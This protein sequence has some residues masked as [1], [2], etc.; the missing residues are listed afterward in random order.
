M[1]MTGDAHHSKVSTLLHV[2]A[3]VHLV[4]CPLCFYDHCLHVLMTTVCNI[5][6]AAIASSQRSS[7]WLKSKILLGTLGPVPRAK[8]NELIHIDPDAPMAPN[9]R[10]QNLACECLVLPVVLNMDCE[11]KARVQSIV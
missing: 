3:A 6:I 10:A 5:G 8:V 7:K 2:C 9:H 1:A 4:C 11:V